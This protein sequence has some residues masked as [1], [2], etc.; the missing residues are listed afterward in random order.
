MN[1]LVVTH[2]KNQILTALFNGKTMLE[3][4]CLQEDASSYV[5]NIYIGR[6]ENIVPSINAAFVEYIKGVKGY[7]S[8]AENPNPVF[9]NKKN[10]TKPCIGDLIL[11]Q[12]EREPVKT[13]AA[14]LTTHINLPGKYAVL[15]D[16]SRGSVM[17]SDK[18]RNKEQKKHIRELATPYIA[19]SYGIV[20]RTNCATASDTEICDEL[21]ALLLLH[22]DIHEKAMHR[23][24]FTCL[25]EE[26][27]GFLRTIKNIRFE[28]LEE[29]IT[30]DFEIYNQIAAFL[31]EH[32]L[33]KEMLHLYKDSLV[34]LTALFSIESR[35]KEAL[36]ERVWLKSG[37]Y[38]IIQPTEAL[39]VIDVNTG[40]FSGNKKDRE[41]TFY[42]INLEAAMEI[43]HQIR[44]RNYSG[45]ILIDFIDMELAENN[46]NLIV[47]LKKAIATDP[48]KTTYVDMTSLGLIELTRKK[49]QKPLY[50]QINRKDI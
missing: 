31:D 32:N 12:V 23:T 8:L 49:V 6:I 29:I 26:E 42:K 11:I 7:L 25:H 44:L 19:D 27:N 15:V 45:I 24:A 34:S 43:A 5:G 17:I 22:R 2:Y 48:I 1:K 28:Y 3:A 37:G 40:K 9:I 14:V 10:T 50:E 46:T 13:K 33:S 38:L 21:E 47:E 36:S 39:V 4:S 20:M 30:D 16:D 18:I 35:M 41:A